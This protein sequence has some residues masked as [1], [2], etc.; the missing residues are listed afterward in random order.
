MKLPFPFNRISVQLFLALLL[1]AVAVALNVFG[2][3]RAVSPAPVFTD[4]PLYTKRERVPVV[5]RS[6]D[7]I[8]TVLHDNPWDKAIGWDPGTD[9][10]TRPLG[11]TMTSAQRLAMH[12][13]A[14]GTVI[15]DLDSCAYMIFYKG[16]WKTIR[17]QNIH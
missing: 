8:R 4:S 7:S 13:P 14:V 16:G 17:K 5:N 11:P 2:T 10:A 3:P 15:K 1:L 12:D 6:P 9:W